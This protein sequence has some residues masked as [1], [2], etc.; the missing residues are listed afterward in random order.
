MI[1]QQTLSHYVAKN[2]KICYNFC[3]ITLR[4]DSMNAIITKLKN[5][6]V[7]K[8]LKYSQIILNRFTVKDISST[9]STLMPKNDA[10]IS[11][12]EPALDYSFNCS[13][14]IT[15]IALSGSYGSGKS[16]II[17][18]YEKK[19]PELKFIHISLAHFN[20]KDIS[21]PIDIGKLE[22]TEE[23]E[24]S[25][26]NVQPNKKINKK[27]LSN[28]LEGKILNQ[29]IH[30]V[31]PSNI[32]ESNFNIKHSVSHYKKI[33]IVLSVFILL[34]SIMYISFYKNWVWTLQSTKWSFFNFT[35]TSEFKIILS[36]LCISI[37][38][39]AVSSFVNKTGLFRQ[40]KK[41]D[42]KNLVGIEIFD[43]STDSSF[44]R[45]LNEVVYLF[46]KSAADAI[47][48]E[49]LDRY[50]TLLI[51]EKL[52]EINYLVNIHTKKPLRFFYLIKDDIFTSNDRSKFFDFII[53]VVPVVD[54]TNSSDMLSKLLVST[55]LNTEVNQQLINDLAFYLNDMRL[56]TNI[57]NEYQIYKKAIKVVPDRDNFTNQFAMIVYKNLFP[58]DFHALQSGSGYVYTVFEQKKR[59][60]E[61][62]EKELI[63]RK[64]K[65]TN[66]LRL[67]E[68]S[69]LKNIDELNALYFPLNEKVLQIDDEVI[70]EDIER[71]DLIKMIINCTKSVQFAHLNGIKILDVQAAL[72]TMNENPEYQSRLNKIKLFSSESEELSKKAL[73]DI[74]NEINLLS[75]T[76]LRDLISSDKESSEFWGSVDKQ[77]RNEC[78]ATTSILNDRNH[79]LIKYLIFNGYINENYEAYCSYFYSEDLSLQDRN[80]I[81]SVYNGKKTAPDYKL[82]NAEKVL[83]KINP[84]SF[85][86]EYVN[87]YDLLDCVIKTKK[88]NL[89]EIWF[90]TLENNVAGYEFIINF[91]RNNKNNKD[92][93]NYLTKN[94]SSWI[95]TWYISKAIT[96]DEFYELIFSIVDYCPKGTL[97]Q[98][99]IDN[100]LTTRISNDTRFLSYHA[101]DIDKYC[102][103][104]KNITV[105][106]TTLE[107][108]AP[109]ED[110]LKFVYDHN[111][112]AINMQNISIIVKRYT[113]FDLIRNTHRF[114]TFLCKNNDKPV[115]KYLF[116]NINLFI[117]LIVNF[118][119]KKFKDE[120]TAI[121][122]VINNPLLHDENKT[123]Y[124]KNSL[125]KVRTLSEIQD[126]TLW[127]ELLKLNAFLNSWKNLA[128]YYCA[129]ELEEGVISE[130]LAS[131]MKNATGLSSLQYKNLRKL[132]STEC[133]NALIL[134]LI[135]STFFD[136][137]SYEKLI[138]GMYVTY[139]SFFAQSLLSWQLFILFK[140]NTIAK[141]KDNF[142][143]IKQNYSKNLLD[144]ILLGDSK[145]LFKLIQDS[146]II[147]EKAEILELLSDSRITN[148]FS[149]IL[150]NLYTG[151]ITIENKSYSDAVC[152]VIIQNH[153]NVDDLP[154]LLLHYDSLGN[155]TKTALIEYAT[156]NISR[157][158]SA[159]K[160]VKTLPTEIFAALLILES[161][162]TKTILD[163]RKILSDDRFE[164]VCS[165][166]K[167]PSFEDNEHN[168]VILEYFKVHGWISSYSIIN[169]KMRAYPKRKIS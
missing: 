137:I 146:T 135:K 160:T 6:L 71:V 151:T 73:A 10:D 165:S 87:N 43:S 100:W 169:D 95:K 157:I 30:Q 56:L 132:V 67:S 148:E 107:C 35:L 36:L 68:A 99:N 117:P 82:Q 72:L 156:K 64:N 155:K 159:A 116:E 16:S 26:S 91:W 158:T 40:L 17:G 53:P 75:T 129:I 138:K 77:Y 28:I 13:E 145:K 11:S 111:M 70:S 54:V 125:I 124:M 60:C 57:V 119:K 118:S 131:R 8:M 104:L 86:L 102:D 110:I 69:M 105:L 49:D 149:L 88:Y 136:E 76:R 52:R 32:P 120:Q 21:R 12:Y 134:N 20:N 19:H 7:E 144:F 166:S 98:I 22:T 139:N 44:D 168:R 4:G 150:L 5:F 24:Q 37:I 89:L 122:F 41:I 46:E 113:K 108:S 121:L 33:Q 96:D 162:D 123:L 1:I 112:Y 152:E 34:L 65:I 47:I 58:E 3:N 80:F 85:M 130:T 163:F 2:G 142:D 103:E 31:N 154:W 93:I 147:L 63:E 97:S 115:S 141:T 62:K 45:Y 140:T 25:D 133:A 94:F 59:F 78:R 15:N 55:G 27:E 50:D 128:T 90:S 9:Y 126:K 38:F 79:K 74:S 66:D 164:L 61:E 153:F 106:F 127:P 51:F 23:N 39:C 29:L 161:I 84:S 109:N 101:D 14:K 114:C 167:S 18:T 42:I 143:F 48:F 92:L 81:M 83:E